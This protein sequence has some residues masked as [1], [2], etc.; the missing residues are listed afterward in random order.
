MLLRNSIFL[1]SI[2]IDISPCDSICYKSLLPHRAYRSASRNIERI[3]AYRKSPQGFISMGLLRSP[4]FPRYQYNTAK[5][6]NLPV[7][8]PPA[9]FQKRRKVAE[10]LHFSPLPK[11]ALIMYT[12]I[13]SK[14]GNKKGR[15]MPPLL[16][17]S[18][19]PA[20]RLPYPYLQRR[21]MRQSDFQY[22]WARSRPLSS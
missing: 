5:R 11:N 4:R 3:S 9:I 6:K 1:P 2:K 16:F 15:Q 8:F 22:P 12:C 7:F 10:T 20:G 19:C 13:Q 21:N 18:S 14:N 17:T